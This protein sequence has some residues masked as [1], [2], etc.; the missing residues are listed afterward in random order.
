MTVHFRSVS[1]F[2]AALGRV[3][4]EIQATLRPRLVEAGNIVAEDARQ[5]ASWSSRIPGAIS[6]SA[7]ITRNG[8]VLIRVDSEAA[9]HARPYEGL[10]A[11]GASG[12]F[13]HP[14]FDDPDIP[15]QPQATRPFL[16][17]AVDADRDEVVRLVEEA[18]HEATP[19]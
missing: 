11:G 16:Q 5:N 12:V 9:P 14:V 2:A 17:P 4:A 13:R 15:W 7:P 10:S 1:E 3:P 19:F 6:V 8:G 18:V